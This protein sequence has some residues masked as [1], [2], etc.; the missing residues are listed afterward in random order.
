M[1]T[2]MYVCGY[3]LCAC[4]YNVSVCTG[5]NEYL[6]VCVCFRVPNDTG[7]L[8]LLSKFPLYSIIL[9]CTQSTQHSRLG[10]EFSSLIIFSF[11]AKLI[12]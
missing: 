11:S 6:C 8:L 3:K 9:M 10:H 12:V 7:G 2:C 1:C 4:I 5:M